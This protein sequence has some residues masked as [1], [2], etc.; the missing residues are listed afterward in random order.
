MSESVP[1]P[2]HFSASVIVRI[3]TSCAFSTISH[4]KPAA[5]S[6]SASSFAARGLT[7]SSTKRFDGFEDRLWSSLTMKIACAI[8]CPSPL[9]S[10]RR[11][12]GRRMLST[13]ARESITM[14]RMRPGLP[15]YSLNASA[16]CVERVGVRDETR[17]VDL[18]RG[19]EVD[20][21]A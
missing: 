6:G 3:P 17:H 13:A 16:A 8:G 10:R 7:S 1:R 20:R 4:E 15:S 19:D 5:G 14:R 12:A 2:P 11:R 18:P 9:R 21:G